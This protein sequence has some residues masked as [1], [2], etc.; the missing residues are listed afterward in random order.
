[1][2]SIGLILSTM[3][4]SSPLGF[5]TP[6]LGTLAYYLLI[7]NRGRNAEQILDGDG[8]S[9]KQIKLKSWQRPSTI[10]TL[11]LGGFFLVRIVE[12]PSSQASWFAFEIICCL[13]FIIRD[14]ENQA[15]RNMD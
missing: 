10:L 9:A 12:H 5:L 14:L 6:A 1:M 8:A 11:I 2:C 4:G 13:A 15:F 7:A 3:S